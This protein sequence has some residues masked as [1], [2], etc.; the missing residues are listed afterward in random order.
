MATAEQKEIVE[1]YIRKYKETGDA[2]YKKA[3]EY[4]GKKFGTEVKFEEESKKKEE[5]GGK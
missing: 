5:K 1:F 4:W 3:A 2:V